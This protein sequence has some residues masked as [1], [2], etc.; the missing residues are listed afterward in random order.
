MTTTTSAL[1][2]LVDLD[3]W[4]AERAAHEAKVELVRGLV[5]MAPSEGAVNLRSGWLIAHAIE[6]ATGRERLAVPHLDVVLS[7][8]PTTVRCP[9]LVVVRPAAIDRGTTRLSA[10]DVDL[11]AEVVSPSSVETDWLVKR[12]EYARAGIGAYLVVD[13]RPGAE[14]LALFTRPGPDGY[15]DVTGGGAVVIPFGDDAV[16]LALGD[17]LA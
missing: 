14:R 6:R 17:L 5:I 13:L 3:G 1:P 4:A 7:D 15:A 16:H 12:A 2:P 9:D 10:A 8:V 11:V